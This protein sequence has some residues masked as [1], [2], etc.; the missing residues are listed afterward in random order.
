MESINQNGWERMRFERSF[1]FS[2]MEKEL[3]ANAYER[4]V[5]VRSYRIKSKGFPPG[6]ETVASKH[7]VKMGGL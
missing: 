7:F 1:A 4:L 5:P 3:M 2:R 6:P